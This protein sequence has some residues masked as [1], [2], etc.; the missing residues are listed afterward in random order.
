LVV[1]LSEP[2]SSQTSTVN[3]IYAQNERD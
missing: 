1:S 3:N 2:K